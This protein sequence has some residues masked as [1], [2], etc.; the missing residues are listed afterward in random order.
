[1]LSCHR[2]VLG[3]IGIGILKPNENLN[4][5]GKFPSPGKSGELQQSIGTSAVSDGKIGSGVTRIQD[6]YLRAAP[7]VR[8]GSLLIKF[9]RLIILNNEYKQRSIGQRKGIG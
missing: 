5:G 8:S 2:C 3:S 4:V 1:M 6:Y 9:P 7:L